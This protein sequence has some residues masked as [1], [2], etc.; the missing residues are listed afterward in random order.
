MKRTLYVTDLDGTLMRDDKTISNESIGIINDLIG[1]GMLFTCATARSISSAGRV[2]KGIRLPLPIIV[3][4][5]TILADGGSGEEIE[6]ILFTQ[7]EAASVRECT[8]G[9]T[10]PGFVTSYTDGK[11]AKLYIDGI[12]N[13]GFDHYLADHKNDRRLRSV[14]AEDKLYEGSLC[15]FTFIGW[16][17]FPEMRQRQKQLRG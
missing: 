3:R 14:S 1:Q 5:G 12:S 16:K 8:K 9:M 15:Y 17:F 13:T 10:V 11:Q 6:I 2:I 7:E 4:N